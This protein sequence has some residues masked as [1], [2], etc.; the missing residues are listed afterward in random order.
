MDGVFL[1]VRGARGLSPRGARVFLAM[2]VFLANL[3]AK[4]AKFGE[5]CHYY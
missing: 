5:F 4:S 2:R 3:G 1:A